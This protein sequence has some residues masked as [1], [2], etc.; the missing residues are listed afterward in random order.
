MTLALLFAAI[1]LL[2]LDWRQ[3]LRIFEQRRRELNPIIRW[4]YARCGTRG[5]DG[6]FAAWIAVVLT[7]HAFVPYGFVGSALLALVQAFVVTRNYRRGI[8]L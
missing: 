2:A 5:I 3:T 4:A 8:K 1:V 6:Y 7:F